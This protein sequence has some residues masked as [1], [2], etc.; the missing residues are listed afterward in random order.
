M[1]GFPVCFVFLFFELKAH[2]GMSL[3]PIK[4]KMVVY[5]VLI[6]LL[7]GLRFAYFFTL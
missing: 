6:S 5:C 3:K 2:M 1:V 7:I 4:N